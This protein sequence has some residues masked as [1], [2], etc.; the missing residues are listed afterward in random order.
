MTDNVTEFPAPPKPPEL[1]IGP[2]EEWRVMV[3]GRIIP[4]LT[5]FRE[6]PDHI[7]F[8]LDHRF[9]VTVPNDCAHGVAYVIA[10]ALAIGQGYP[11]MNAETKDR[12]F[13]PKGMEVSPPEGSPS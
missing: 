9:G 1:L 4:R 3:D 13:A 6:G 8:V 2:F 11:S 5:G 12:P 7:C 10:N